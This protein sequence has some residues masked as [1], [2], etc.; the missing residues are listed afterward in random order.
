MIFWMLV[1]M[2]TWNVTNIEVISLY[3]VANL[4]IF[5]RIQSQTRLEIVMIFD[6]FVLI[7]TQCLSDV[8][9]DS[10]PVVVNTLIDL[11]I[12]FQTNLEIVYFWRACLHS[13]TTC[14]WHQPISLQIVADHIS[15]LAHLS[16]QNIGDFYSNDGEICTLVKEW[17]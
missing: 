8:K 14:K 7:A 15:I 10:L 6:M 9:P 17:N 13:H 2:A 3:V 1:F 11:W 4:L 16:F 5:I 12:Q